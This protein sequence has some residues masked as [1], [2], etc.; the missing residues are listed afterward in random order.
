[1]TNEIKNVQPFQL[2]KC[3]LLDFEAYDSSINK[4]LGRDIDVEIVDFC[5][6][7]YEGA[8]ED[9]V[10]AALEKHFG[11]EITSI[12]TDGISHTETG[13]WIVYK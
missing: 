5:D 2:K 9:E 7:Y 13:V 8:D 10:I 4:L 1:M 3:I 6:L 12:H 11:V